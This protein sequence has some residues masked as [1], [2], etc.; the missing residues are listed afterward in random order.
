MVS[1]GLSLMID[2]KMDE[3]KNGWALPFNWVT[4]LQ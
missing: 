1:L 4:L 3:A 2:Q